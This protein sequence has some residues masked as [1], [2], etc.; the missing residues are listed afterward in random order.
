MENVSTWAVISTVIN[1][2]I[3]IIAFFGSRLITGMQTSIENAD[4]KTSN[5]FQRV[6][7]KLETFQTV[8]GCQLAH[9][10][11]D[12]IHDIESD[13]REKETGR[14]QKDIDNVAQI[15]RRGVA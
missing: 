11:H 5:S 6:F 14:L 10:N 9:A 4:E 8:K 7:D 1:V 13:Q 2:L 15:A 12:K 3:M